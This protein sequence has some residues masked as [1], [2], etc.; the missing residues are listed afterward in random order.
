MAGLVSLM[1][2]ILTWAAFAREMDERICQLVRVSK[3][4]KFFL[5]FFIRPRNPSSRVGNA[6]EGAWK[7]SF[8]I[9]KGFTQVQ[10]RIPPGMDS[11]SVVQKR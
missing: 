1:I 6:S 9:F 8:G 5:F 7:V 3:S 11:F 2:W 10:K 4:A